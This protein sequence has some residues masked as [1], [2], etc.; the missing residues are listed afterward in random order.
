MSWRS[1]HGI[2]H[3]RIP[4]CC[5]LLA[6]L[7]DTS[8]RPPRVGQERAAWWANMDVRQVHL[9]ASLESLWRFIGASISV[10]IRLAPP[11]NNL[12]VQ[13]YLFNVYIRCALTM[14]MPMTAWPGVDSFRDIRDNAG[15]PFQTTLWQFVL[16]CAKHF[17]AFV[18]FFSPENFH[19]LCRGLLIIR[20]G[21]FIRRCNNCCLH[22]R[23]SHNSPF[24][25]LTCETSSWRLDPFLQPCLQ[26]RVDD[27]R[28]RGAALWDVRRWSSQWGRSGVEGRANDAPRLWNSRLPILVFTGEFPIQESTT[29]CLIMAMEHQISIGRMNFQRCVHNWLS[30][31]NQ[32]IAPLL[33]LVAETLL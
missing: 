2:R 28:R 3:P 14:L 15:C 8:G 33:F 10:R 30:I 16:T 26:E 32:T 21:F 17:V 19:W 23:T 20:G 24:L 22:Q 5:Q 6:I 18:C 31:A 27:A 1:A 12:F 4:C 7:T 29:R 11:S 25:Q 13:C 9:H